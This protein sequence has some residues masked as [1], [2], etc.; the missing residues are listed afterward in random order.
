MLFCHI[1]WSAVCAIEYKITRK[2]LCEYLRTFL[3]RF[4]VINFELKDCVCVTWCG[5]W[6]VSIY[7]SCLEPGQP[8]LSSL[9]ISPLP[10]PWPLSTSTLTPAR[11]T[12][13]QSSWFSKRVTNSQWVTQLR[14]SDPRVVLVPRDTW[15]VFQ[16]VW[17]VTS[18]GGP[19]EAPP[20]PAPAGG[21]SQESV[22]RRAPRSPHKPFTALLR[23][24]PGNKI[25]RN[26][27]NICRKCTSKINFVDKVPNFR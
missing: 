23:A 15:H 21:S 4:V 20:S 1:R 22:G 27:H 25:S 17:R 10:R 9:I 18:P 12:W 3:K 24:K 8:L 19:G 7:K 11:D 5:V 16:S 26:F 6:S 14:D 2:K 13:Q